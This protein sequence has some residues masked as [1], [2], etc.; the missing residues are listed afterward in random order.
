L[1]ATAVLAQD[2][3][4]VSGRAVLC[5]GGTVNEAPADL[6]VSGCPPPA[7]PIDPAPAGCICE[8]DCYRGDD[9][10]YEE[11]A[12]YADNNNWLYDIAGDGQCDDVRDDPA[13][14][15]SSTNR[16]FCEWGHDCLDCGPRCPSAASARKDPHF[17]FAHG[18]RADIRGYHDKVF[19]FL[20]AKNV[21]FNVRISEAD[22]HWRDRLVHGTKMSAA[23]WVMRSSPSG[24]L[25]FVEYAGARNSSGATVHV[26]WN[27]QGGET[28][29]K[30]KVTAGKPFARENLRVSL[31]E[32]RSLSVISDRWA[33]SARISPFPFAKLNPNQVLLDVQAMPKYDADHDVVAP[34]GLFGQTFDGD[35]IAVS[36]ATDDLD[37]RDSREPSSPSEVKTTAQGEGAIEGTIDDY[38]LA[39][40][41]STQFK[42]SRFDATAA[43]PRD[44]SKLAGR[45]TKR[46]HGKSGT[47]NT[48][49]EQPPIVSANTQE[50]DAEALARA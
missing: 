17:R 24:S 47:Q 7:P 18:G 36:G 16:N 35:D 41:W 1:F 34:H 2:H 22:F 19:N 40:R 50:S 45:K 31:S 28:W 9:A 25:V 4:V 44:A 30:V 23:Y 5:A 33:L 42:Y 32:E 8:N 10:P 49:V 3:P 29:S 43:R 48:G 11:Y 6:V 37:Q 26:K 12:S 27:K 14:P 13:S 20:S 39:D 15:L 46:S 21:S 38:V